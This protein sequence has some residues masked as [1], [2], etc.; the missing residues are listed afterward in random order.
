MNSIQLKICVN[1]LETSYTQDT[2]AQLIVEGIASFKF[3]DNGEN[4]TRSLA[5]RAFGQAAVSLQQAGIGSVHVAQGRLNIYP[6]SENNLNERPVLTITSA[7][8]VAAQPATQ[9]QPQAQVTILT[10]ASNE[11]KNPVLVTEDIPF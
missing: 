9:P 10:T 8:L 4:K 1:H 6:R 11:P 3:Y 5:F 7:I 2:H